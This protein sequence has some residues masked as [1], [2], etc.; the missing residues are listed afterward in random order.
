[1]LP[2][3][4]AYESIS[5]LFLERCDKSPDSEAYRYP[6]DGD[7]ESLTWGESRERVRAIA[8]G[9][10]SLGLESEQRVGILCSTRVE[11]ILADLGILCAAGA[12]TTVYPSNTAEEC[13]FI[14][15]DSQTVMIFAE[16]AEQVAKLRGVK[17]QLPRLSKV[18]VIEGEGDDDWV[19]S[20]PDLEDLGE[21]YLADNDGA[22]EERAR[23]PK[24]S[25]L[26][27]LIY[28]SGTT[29]KPKGVELLHS[30]WTYTAEGIA[31][32]GII[33]END[34]QYLW[35]PLSHSFGKVLEVAQLALG[36]P[37]AVDGRIPKLVDNLAVVRPTFMAAAPRIFE[38]VYNKIIGQTRDA[39]GLKLKIFR[40][41]VSV[42]TEV[43]RLR[44]RRQEPRGLLAIKAAIADKLVFSKIRDR[45]GGRLRFFIS[46]SAPL[47]KDIA[48]FF[49]AAGILILEGYGLTETS[50]ATF[51]NRP[52]TFEF[53]SV[54]EALEGTEVKIAEEDGEILIRGPGVMRGY[55]NLADVTAE[56]LT[57]DGWL[58]TGDIGELDDKG[59]LKITD[60]KKDL[61][62]TS[63]GKYV[64]PQALEG[65]LKA[66]CPYVSQVIVHGDRRNYC[67]A[68]ITL[69]EEG[70]QTWA[71]E[72]GL[73]GAP[74][75]EIAR[76]DK[77]HQLIQGY[78]DE[79]NTKLA[80]YETIKKFTL[81]EKDL[82][83]E[84]GD[85]TPSLKVKRKA[86]EKK[87]MA[88]LDSMY[89]GAIQQMA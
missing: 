24:A 12:T 43:S 3:M 1:M 84:D 26:A 45:F 6:V 47:S 77:A 76:S 25:D 83:V 19:I 57:D 14:L 41:A 80:R 39:G 56:V 11:W 27:T 42:G 69:D 51:V 70:I 10:M 8:G 37:T 30:C 5:E 33:H 86:V 66:M 38:K 21:R 36:F 40:W 13:E 46:G 64:A 49:H 16:N 58:H 74:Y 65:Q 32:I 71:G 79:L 81:L 44:Q 72:N 88:T 89:E 68:L 15:E 4:A 22:F 62:K 67:T 17:A 55:H 2:A 61:I 35:L 28:T 18:I 59:L 52:D 85:L 23:V 73:S 34:L 78:I 60:R 54:G 63:G 9:L 50:A 48:E 29:G 31:N 20:L 82:T 87:H 53:G 75:A 7:W